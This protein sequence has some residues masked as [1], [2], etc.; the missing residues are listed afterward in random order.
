MLL[1]VEKKYSHSSFKF[2]VR[3]WASEIKV[4]NKISATKLITLIWLT[5]YDDSATLT[6]TFRVFTSLTL[7]R[8][9]KG[10]GTGKDLV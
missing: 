10:K 1:I 6:D 4:F 8:A 9:R 3:G 7:T 2:L 5:H